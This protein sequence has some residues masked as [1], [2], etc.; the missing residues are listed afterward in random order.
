MRVCE[1]MGE[2]GTSAQERGGLVSGGCERGIDWWVRERGTSRREIVGL[3][4]AR[5]R[6][7][8]A[9]PL[10]ERGMAWWAEERARARERERERERRDDALMH[11]E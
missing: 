1:S 2:R 9:R 5:E 7:R 3:A 8:Q 6:D 11:H 10:R 4:G